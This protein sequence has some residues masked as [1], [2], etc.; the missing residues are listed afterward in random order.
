MAHWN[1]RQFIG[2]T[3]TAT[4]IAIGGRAAPVLGATASIH[5]F[6]LVQSTAL[7]LDA[8]HAENDLQRNL[9]RMLQIIE[10]H[11]TANDWIAFDDAPLT[12]HL[13]TSLPV[14]SLALGDEDLQ[15]LADAA[16]QQ[17]CWIS[18]GAVRRA[19]D[20]II[21]L[22]PQG[23]IREWAM[24]PRHAPLPLQT[25]QTDSSAALPII[26]INDHRLALMP[27]DATDEAVKE[28]SEL[29]VDILITM[30]SGARSALATTR[31]LLPSLSMHVH[32]ASP[33]K[34]TGCEA[35]GVG[36]SCALDA[37]GDVIAESPCTG[38]HV[39]IL[40]GL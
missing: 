2:T 16:S 39:L 10:H 31:P 21:L 5:R 40:A 18:F 19:R 4:V 23:E 9:E 11:A 13:A 25:N 26:E 17:Q 20:S 8:A 7:P 24:P 37:R 22:S 15:K 12:G 3:L 35:A 36:R 33:W 1:R 29:G 38:E 30:G 6:A 27:V 14:T 32:A 28:C 34:P